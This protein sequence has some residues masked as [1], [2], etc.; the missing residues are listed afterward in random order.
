[1]GLFKFIRDLKNAVENPYDSDINPDH[2][3][4]PICGSIMNFFGHDPDNEDIDWDYGEGYWECPDCG[5]KVT[6]DEL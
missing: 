1:M 3:K 4:C 6:E 2:P 5:Y